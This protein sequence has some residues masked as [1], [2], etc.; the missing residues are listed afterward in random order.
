MCHKGYIFNTVALDMHFMKGLLSVMSGIWG[1]SFF[2][3]LLPSAQRPGSDFAGSPLGR[4]RNPELSCTVFFKYKHLKM[5][6]V[7][8]RL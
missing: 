3:G 6:R 1:A 2:L 5:F 4:H 8:T 7:R